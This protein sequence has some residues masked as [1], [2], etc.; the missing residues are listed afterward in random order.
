MCTLSK[1]PDGAL[2]QWAA[3]DGII[4]TES[5]ISGRV[6]RLDVCAH[7]FHWAIQYHNKLNRVIYGYTGLCPDAHPVQLQMEGPSFENFVALRQ[8]PAYKLAMEYAA[9]FRAG[10]REDLIFLGQTGLGKTHLAKAIERVLTARHF[11][12]EFVTAANLQRTFGEAESWNDDYQSRGESRDRRKRMSESD[13]LIVDDLGSERET[14]SELFQ[15]ALMEFWDDRDE[16]RSWIVTTN[17]SLQALG[18][19][20]GQKLFSRLSQHATASQFT[21]TD[22]RQTRTA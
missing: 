11:R 8:G 20:Y 7:G 2:I 22:F 5:L 6:D 16:K 15:Q 13:L 14:K 9:R 17:L 19:R 21:G 3:Q 12:V 4:D 1:L 18:E 10:R